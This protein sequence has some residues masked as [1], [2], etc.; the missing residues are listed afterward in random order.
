MIQSPS[1]LAV[2]GVSAIVDRVL[3]YIM[4]PIDSTEL[5][6]SAPALLTRDGHIRGLD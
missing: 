2:S 6:H 3:V 1:V 4:N 5:L